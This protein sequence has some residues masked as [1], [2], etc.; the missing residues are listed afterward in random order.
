MAKGTKRIMIERR[1]LERFIRRGLP[2]EPKLVVR[3]KIG[4]IPQIYDLES[5]RPFRLPRD[6]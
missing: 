4:K 1:R 6:H 2:V 5:K 3:A